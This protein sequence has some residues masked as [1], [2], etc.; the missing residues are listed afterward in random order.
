VI[1]FA[2]STASV[3][4]VSLLRREV[5][6]AKA[7]AEELTTKAL[8]RCDLVASELACETKEHADKCLNVAKL[9]ETAHNASIESIKRMDV[10]ID[11]LNHKLLATQMRGINPGHRA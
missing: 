11:D 3:V 9:L 7:Y 4:Y 5:D 2:A 8:N 1:L 10:K 6:A